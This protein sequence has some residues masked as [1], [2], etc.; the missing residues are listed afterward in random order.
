MYRP[1]LGRTAG[2]I[3]ALGFSQRFLSVVL[4][5]VRCGAAEGQL[6]QVMAAGS[7]PRVYAVFAL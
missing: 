4:R 3:F 7:A 2:G 1:T 6:R 5:V